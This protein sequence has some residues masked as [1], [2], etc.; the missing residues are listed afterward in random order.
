MKDDPHPKEV[1]LIS[2]VR[3]FPSYSPERN[4]FTLWKSGH[5]ETFISNC[6]PVADDKGIH[7]KILYEGSPDDVPVEL[8][9]KLLLVY[10]NGD[11]NWYRKGPGTMSDICGG[12]SP[13]DQ[14]RGRKDSFDLFLAAIDFPKK[15]FIYELKITEDEK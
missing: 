3:K 1:R 11:G 5:D 9:D 2:N 15:I 8:L 14:A 4:Y 6:I 13:E 10:K 12:D 7:I